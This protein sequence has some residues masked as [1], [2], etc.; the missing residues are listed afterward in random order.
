M[1]KEADTDHH[2][3]H[4]KVENFS[5]LIE[6]LLLFITCF[7]ICWEAIHR[8]MSGNIDIKINILS[9]V[10]VITSIVID[11]WR[12]KKLMRA[13]KKYNSQ[14]VEADA[15]HFSTDIWSSAVVLF[16]LICVSLGSLLGFKWLFYADSV[17]ALMVAIIVIHVSYKM[18]KKSIDSLLD[19]VPFEISKDIENVIK[20][21]DNI[22]SYHGFKVRQ[23]GHI[24]FVD[25]TVHVLC[26][27]L[28]EAHNI[29]D[30]L[31]SKIKKVQ[32]F[33]DVTIHVE[34]ENH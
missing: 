17:A 20:S 31:E 13:A 4:G 14:A 7:W 8:L 19:K 23:S 10:V 28:I 27:T 24:Y 16:G 30:D 18:G 1:L 12:S 9:Y 6:T 21:Y 26:D 11:V 29:S 22:E 34:P 15:L 33:T 32:P 25:V 3:G 5:A 2:Y